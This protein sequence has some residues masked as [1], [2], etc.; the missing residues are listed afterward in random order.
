MSSNYT[1]LLNEWI[2][3]RNRSPYNSPQAEDEYTFAHQ[4]ASHNPL[5][6]CTAKITLYGLSYSVEVDGAS[7]KKGAKKNGSQ[8]LY[9]IVTTHGE[10]LDDWR[11]FIL[12]QYGDEGLIQTQEDNQSEDNTNL[13]SI[14]ESWSASSSSSF[15]PI[16]YNNPHQLWIIVDAD[17]FNYQTLFDAI[18]SEK[19]PLCHCRVYIGLNGTDREVPGVVVERASGRI[20]DSADVL[21]LCDLTM[22]LMRCGRLDGLSILLVAND[23]IFTNLI[24]VFQSRFGF[25]NLVVSGTGD[26]VEN[27]LGML[28]EME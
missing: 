23:H 16:D 22:D 27:A 12:Q 20:Q 1:S 17:S 8:A 19:K 3:A 24:E 15:A 28:D 7:T 25:N 26:A 9:D 6:Y 14:S 5:F 11:E 10:S 18:P 21:L 13:L 4:G 2:Q